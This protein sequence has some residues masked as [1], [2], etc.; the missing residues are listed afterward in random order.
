MCIKIDDRYLMLF[1][2]CI[3][4][5]GASRSIICDIQ[6]NDFV[7]IPNFFYDIFI[8]DNIIPFEKLT[9]KYSEFENFIEEF[10]KV[11]E[12][13]LRKEYLFYTNEPTNFSPISPQ[14]VF[15]SIITNAIIDIEHKISFNIDL[16]IRQLTSLCC[17]AVSIR[18]FTSPKIEDL[19]LLL[20]K[21]HNSTIRSIEITLPMVD[22]LLEVNNIE[23]FVEEHP[24]CKRII[25]YNTEGINKKIE[26]SYVK[27]IYTEFKMDK[28][29][30]CGYVSP[31]Y[32]NATNYSYLESKN[33]NNCLHK[34]ISVDSEGNIKNCPSMKTSWG[35]YDDI[36]SLD[37]VI[38][39]PEFTSLWNVSKDQVKVCQDCEFRYICHDC[40]AFITNENDPLSK[41][42]RCNYNPYDAVWE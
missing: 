21:F 40:R 33:H 36:Q 15:P 5:K 39:L 4:V 7:F 12:T 42:L 22:F 9:E 13:L 8:M 26:L 3:P 19:N 30:C 1:A 38:K 17:Q 41:P 28:G 6:R 35:K 27:V 16:F 29:N 14:K 2:C 11:I 23:F 32:F 31:H 18:Y 37:K 34:K 25:I 20:K 24:R 10:N